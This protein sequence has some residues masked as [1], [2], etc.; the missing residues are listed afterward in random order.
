MYGKK[1]GMLWDKETS[2][3]MQRFE[4]TRRW[5]IVGLTLTTQLPVYS[6]QAI[7]TQIFTDASQQDIHIPPSCTLFFLLPAPL[8]KSSTKQ[9]HPHLEVV[10][11]NAGIPWRHFRL[12][13]LSLI[14]IILRLCW[15]PIDQ[16]FRCQSALY[17]HF[18][19]DDPLPPAAGICY[20]WWSNC[21]ITPPQSRSLMN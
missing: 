17:T 13:S 16:G 6:L 1:V 18:S 9:Q 4:V 19:N 3:P 12:Y 7:L 15:V 11:V 2:R 8:E 20:C 14:D 21:I 5:S 10:R